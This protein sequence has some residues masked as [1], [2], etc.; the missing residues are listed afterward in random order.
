MKIMLQSFQF[1]SSKIEL[2]FYIV[3]NDRSQAIIGYH[4]VVE[5]K[6]RQQNQPSIII[7][8][9]LKCFYKM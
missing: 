6:D 7:I 1:W 3:A 2:F 4:I 5:K 8:L 9:I